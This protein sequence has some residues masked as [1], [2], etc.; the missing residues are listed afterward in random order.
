MVSGSLGVHLETLWG[1][2][3][4]V[5]RRAGRSVAR[6]AS[7]LVLLSFHRCARQKI[8]K[9]SR[10]AMHVIRYQAWAITRKTLCIQLLVRV[11]LLK[12]S[13]ESTHHF[14]HADAPM[15]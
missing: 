13:L 1:P 15:R 4:T 9:T 12:P 7:K 2:E 10:W 6:E 11:K 3:G 14:V 8:K 5:E